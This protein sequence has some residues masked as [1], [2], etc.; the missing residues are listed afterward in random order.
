M[1]A[2]LVAAACITAAGCHNFNREYAIYCERFGCDADAGD[3]SELIVV[4]EPLSQP[5]G[6]CGAV[7]LRIRLRG[8]GTP[9]THAQ[10]ELS[11]PPVPGRGRQPVISES[12]LCGDPVGTLLI[13]PDQFSVTVT[14]RDTTAG[15]YEQPVRVHYPSAD[16]TVN[17]SFQVRSRG[18][19]LRASR[20]SPRRT[21]AGLAT[22]SAHS[23]SG[24]ATPSA[25]TAPTP[26]PFR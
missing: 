7:T 16:L 13:P 14:L 11:F 22:A 24:S 3:P 15:S 25:M 20:S 9:D 6:E 8:G 26:A 12:A 2:L 5:A 17:G 10:A 21:P 4:A 18:C 19:P 1:R 23:T